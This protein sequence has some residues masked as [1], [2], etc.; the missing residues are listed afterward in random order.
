MT[1]QLLPLEYTDDEDPEVRTG[2]E[3]TTKSTADWALSRA[4]TAKARIADIEAQRDDHIRRTNERADKL[5]EAERRTVGFMEAHLGKW[6]TENRDA[7]L[8]GSTKKSLAFVH[9]TIGWRKRE[10][11]LVVVDEQLLGT[12]LREQDD[13]SLFRIKIEPEMK[14]LQQNFKANGVI[15]PGC[16][17]V[18][19]QEKIY[20]EPVNLTSTLVK[21]K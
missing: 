13:V 20:I 10:G 15:P 7:L 8:Q 2:W 5:I 12:W 17:Y 1:D 14:N 9:G 6:A 18:A 3:I 19:T 4:A 21:G 11:R 16:E